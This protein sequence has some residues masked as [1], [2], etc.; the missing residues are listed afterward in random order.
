MS[1]TVEQKYGVFYS[2]QIKYEKKRLVNKMFYLLQITD[3][4]TRSKYGDVDVDSAFEDALFEISGLNDVMFEP[5]QLATVLSLLQEARNKYNNG[6][7]FQIVRK[8]ILDSGNTI[9]KLE[10][11]GDSY[12]K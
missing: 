12:A 10:D 11:G 4:E 9:K 5:K 2:S 1:N 6:E 3:S 8:L 7:D